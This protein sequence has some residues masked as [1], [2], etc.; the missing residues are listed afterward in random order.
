MDNAVKFTPEDG[1]IGLEVTG[2]S[3]QREVRFTV[4]D[5]GIGIAEDDLA[6]LFQP[7]M[8]VDGSL[9]R[10]YEG[11]G[12]G[13]ALA[14]RLVEMHGGAIA[15]ES[16]VGKGSRFTVSLPWRAS[17][18]RGCNSTCPRVDYWPS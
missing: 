3:K 18:E 14:A 9:S 10:S 6:R 8:Q 4:W 16:D 5:T 12:V 1:T 15:V 11:A 2:Y 13:L 7:F 17:K